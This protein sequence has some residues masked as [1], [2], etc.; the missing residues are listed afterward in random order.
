MGTELIERLK[1]LSSADDF[2]RFFGVEHDEHVVHVNRLHIL[3]RFHQY[4]GRETALQGLDD[5][6]LFR[7]YRALLQKAYADFVSSNA[8]QE[9]VFKVFQTADGQHHVS[10]SQLRATLAARQ[11]A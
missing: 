9:K 3:K 6:E 10:L 5:V 2:L 4:I 8:Q 1:T 7:R 11:P